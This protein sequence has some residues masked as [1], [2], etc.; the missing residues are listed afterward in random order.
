MK[1]FSIVLMLIIMIVL[2]IFGIYYSINFYNKND[3]QLVIEATNDGV[4]KAEQNDCNNFSIVTITTQNLLRMYL[5]RY[6]E[7]ILQN[8]EEAYYLLDKEYREKRFQ[9]IEDYVQYVQNNKETY[10]N[11][12]LVSYQVQENNGSNRYICLDENGNYYI[13]TESAVMDYTVMLDTYTIDMPE[14]IEEYNNSTEQQKAAL[15]IER[16]FRALN[17][18][19]YRY[20]YIHLADSFKNNYF[21][22]QEEFESYAKENL[23]ENTKQTYSNF[24]KQ[25]DLYTYS[26]KI[27]NKDTN[28]SV[29]KTF[30]VDLGEGTEF[31]LSFNV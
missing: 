30:I 23:F 8:P 16:F 17:Q 7:K 12:T 29:Q 15:N 22:T 2:I 5:N 6:K 19:D 26:V 13:F 25:S 9:S 24:E 14:F 21:K 1:K 28:E 4:I 18:K 20:A 11:A 27:T 3:E 10:D 31:V